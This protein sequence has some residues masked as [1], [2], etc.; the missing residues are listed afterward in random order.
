MSIQAVSPALIRPASDDASGCHHSSDRRHGR[1]VALARADPN[2]PLECEHEDLPVADFARDGAP[3]ERVDGRLEKRLGDRDLKADLVGE[4]HLHRRPAVGLDALELAPVPLDAADRE[5]RDLGAV[6]R[7]EHVVGLLRAD[8]R[9]DELHRVRVRRLSLGQRSLPP[10]PCRCSVD[11]RSPRRAGTVSRRYQPAFKVPPAHADPGANVPRE[12]PAQMAATV[13]EK[14]RLVTRSD[15]DGLVCAALLKELGILDEIKFVHPKD[16]QDGL[17]EITDRD[18]TTNLPYVPGVRLAFDHHESETLR[19]EESPENHIILPG[20]LSAAR[21]VY[22]YFGGEERFTRVAEELM[23]AVDKADSAMLLAR[24]D[25]RPAGWI[26]L[27]LPDGSPYRAGPLPRLPHLQLRAD[28]AADRRLPGAERRG[29]PRAAGRRGA[30]RALQR[31]CRRRR[32]AAAGALER[33]RQRS[34]SSTCAR[35]R[36]STRPTAS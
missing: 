11:P 6:E 34:S 36:S 29:D 10:E 17:V 23:E 19:V 12:E 24:G 21:V 35:T 26:L 9:D 33:P 15:F 27:E 16:M 30:R 2:G 14:C 5:A 8:D 31:A 25:R 32:G 28:D 7:L 3:A 20:A 1:G 18:I 13:V 22:D 4:L